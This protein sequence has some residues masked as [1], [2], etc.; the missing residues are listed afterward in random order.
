MKKQ[1]VICREEIKEEG[2]YFKVDLFIE[3]KLKGTDFAHQI[4]WVQQNKQ[5]N[6]TKKLIT[7]A[8]KLLKQSGIGSQ[9]DEVFV[10]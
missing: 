9:S 4:C 10:I 8:V 5:N 3:G 1:C 7:G 6:D 2:N